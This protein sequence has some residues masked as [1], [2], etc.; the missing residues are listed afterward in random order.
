[1]SAQTSYTLNISKGLPGLIYDLSTK[2]VVS[3]AVETTAGADFGIVVSR[4]TDKE[5]QIVIGGADVLG[6]TVREISREG[7][8]D[9]SIKYSAKEAAGVMRKGYIWAT[10]PT[11]GTAGAALKYNTTT[12]VIDAGAPAAGEAALTNSTLETTTAAGAVGVIRVN[13]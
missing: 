10:I 1:M 8:A 11:G 12:G 3:R 13:L 4:G 9:G 5:K 2:D 6:V 7:S